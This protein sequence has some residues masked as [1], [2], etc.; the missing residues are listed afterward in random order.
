[1]VKFLKY[2]LAIFFTITIYSSGCTLLS[3]NQYHQGDILQSD[4]ATTKDNYAIYVCDYYPE[5]KIYLVGFVIA[6]GD[7]WYR[8]GIVGEKEFTKAELEKSSIHKISHIDKILP[9]DNSISSITSSGAFGSNDVSTKTT[10]P[11]LRT[12]TPTV[13]R[14]AKPTVSTDEPKFREGDV[15][16]YESGYG[17]DYCYVLGYGKL[18]KIYYTKP[19]MRDYMGWYYTKDI[20]NM[21]YNYDKKYFEEG[22]LIDHLN[23]YPLTKKTS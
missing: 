10:D 21:Q 23:E 11:A 19:I 13:Y 12:S 7:Q 22:S 1:M 9:I 18:K 20:V 3:E 2:L 4:T 14:T 5:T 6:K 17:T 16:K 15:V 8:L